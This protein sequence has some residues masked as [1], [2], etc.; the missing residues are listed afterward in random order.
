[1]TQLIQEEFDSEEEIRRQA[2]QKILGLMPTAQWQIEEELDAAVVSKSINDRVEALQ[3]NR[4]EPIESIFDDFY[5][6]SEAADGQDE[7]IMLEQLKADELQA[8]KESYNAKRIAS[9][10]V[11]K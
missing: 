5:A 2:A 10:L 3:R 4:R 6:D 8:N 11:G 7:Q 9:S 1:M